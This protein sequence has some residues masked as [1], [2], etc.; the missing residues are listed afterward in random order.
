MLC[1]ISVNLVKEDS[2][3]FADEVQWRGEEWKRANRRNFRTFS[4]VFV[5]WR[6]IP[7]VGYGQ[8]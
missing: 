8:R 5:E 6:K 7:I 3:L 2:T 1:R 4:I